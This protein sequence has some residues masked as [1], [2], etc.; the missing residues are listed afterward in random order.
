MF[1]LKRLSQSFAHHAHVYNKLI[2]QINSK[3]GVIY[4]NSA[5]DLNALSAELKD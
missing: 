2:H 4:L 3:V 5:S 1:A